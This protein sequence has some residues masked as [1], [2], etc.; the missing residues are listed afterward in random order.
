M[1]RTEI[2]RVF[3]F[4]V[5]LSTIL[6]PARAS[7]TSDCKLV[8]V[9]T[10]LDVPRYPVVAR[11]GAIQ[12]AV[13]LRIV[14]DGRQLVDVQVESGPAMLAAAA[15]ANVM[16]WEFERHPPVTC[17]V[18]V[19]YLLTD[20]TTSGPDFGVSVLRLPA[21][22]TVSATRLDMSTKDPRGSTSSTE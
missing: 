2:L 16:T 5:L 12:G 6:A 11:A 14:T 19:R 21:E 13:C 4:I 15:I 20:E 22:V 18:V 7:S 17:L 8:P 10:R 9:V 3:S 1:R